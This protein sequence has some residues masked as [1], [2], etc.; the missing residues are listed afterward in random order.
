[1]TGFW[2]PLNKTLLDRLRNVAYAMS[3]QQLDQDKDRR[4][5]RSGYAYIHDEPSMDGPEENSQRG[6]KRTA[7]DAFKYSHVD[8]EE[9]DSEEEEE[10]QKTDATD[11]KMSEESSEEEGEDN[12]DEDCVMV[13]ENKLDFKPHKCPH[14][15]K[16]YTYLV[17]H[18]QLCPHCGYNVFVTPASLK[19]A[20]VSP[21]VLEA[22]LKAVKLK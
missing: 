22:S 19:K 17:H 14:C 18:G 13:D 6:I 12:S 1:M 11:S 9:V 4:P 10:D 20:G 21:P 15:G 5:I 3:Q 8:Y 7:E 16:G 2:E